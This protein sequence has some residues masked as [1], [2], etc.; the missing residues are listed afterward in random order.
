MFIFD[1]RSKDTKDLFKNVVPSHGNYAPKG[2][3]KISI[4]EAVRYT[5]WGS[6]SPCAI[7]YR[8]L[9]KDYEGNKLP[10]MIPANLYYFWD[11]TGIAIQKSYWDENEP[12]KIYRFGCA[13]SYKE[14]SV[15]QAR[16]EGVRHFGRCYHVTKCVKCGHIWS[17]D[18]SD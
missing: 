13:H 1:S 15:G 12:I 9:L 18:S 5:R 17:Y 16:V 10:N 4:L 2:F 11:G 7:E 14:L 8:Q 6:Y 3:K